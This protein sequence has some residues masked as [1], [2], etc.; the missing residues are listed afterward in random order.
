MSENILSVKNI[1]KSFVG[2]QALKDVSMDIK[3]GEVRCLV[4]E[5]GCGKSTLIKIISGAYK[6]DSGEIILGGKS[7][8]KLTPMEAI[9]YGIQVIY[10]D[11]SI[12]PNLT[13]AENIA[14][15]TLRAENTR[16]I[17]WKTIRKTAQAAIE[18]VHVNIDLDKMV[19]TLSVADK[20]LVAICRALTQDAKLIIMDEPTTALTKK[21]VDALM[22]VIRLLKSH[23]ISILFVSHKL[24]EVMEVSDTVTILRNGTHVIDGNIKDFDMTKFAF[25]MTGRELE[26]TAFE[27]EIEDGEELLKVEK[28]SVRGGF[29]DVNF[30]L[31]KGEILGITGLLGSGRTE[32]ALTL[33]GK[34]R[35]S[36]GKIYVNGKRAKIR[37]MQD[38]INHGI[39]YVPE[40]RLSEGLFLTQSIG[41]NIFISVIDDCT[42]KIG[43]IDRQKVKDLIDKMVEELSI[44]TPN[45]DNEVSTLSGGNQQRVVL[46]KWL[47][48]NPQIL[49]LNGPTVGVDIGSKH[50][51]HRILREI[52]NQ[53]IGVIVIS[54]DIPEIMNNCSNILVMKKGRIISRTKN[55]ETTEEVLAAELL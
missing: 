31:K 25:Y 43:S 28:L 33:F 30:T 12:F 6:A 38:A 1:S 32:L 51:I 52:A 39:G 53:G 19:E 22:D 35:I 42:T 48:T 10:Q 13:V 23:D 7:H 3:K 34:H 5:N 37:S 2:V 49:I 9:K 11:F 20:Q 55:T 45:S 36:S 4:G 16:V 14:M 47:A 17:N 27:P 44:K 26:T 21:E 15:N 50:E 18:R 54:D 29:K 46:A 24:D 41:R 40:D 8:K